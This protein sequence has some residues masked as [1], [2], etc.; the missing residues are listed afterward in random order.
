MGE[1]GMPSATGDGTQLVR[2][3]QVQGLREEYTRT[4]EPARARAAETLT[5]KRLPNAECRMLGRPD[6]GGD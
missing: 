1:P 2:G 4:I 6:P 3:C 5:L